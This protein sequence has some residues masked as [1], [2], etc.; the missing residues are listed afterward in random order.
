MSTIPVTPRRTLSNRTLLII[1]LTGLALSILASVLI[2]LPSS[3]GSVGFVVICTIATVP[4][5]SSHR[6]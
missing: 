1:F 4:A 2:R 6:C 5:R 3:S